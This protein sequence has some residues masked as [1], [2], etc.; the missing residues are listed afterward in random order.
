MRLGASAYGASIRRD[1]SERA[2]RDYAIGT[3]YTTMQRLEE[4]RL[5]VS[6]MSE[7]VAIRGGRAKRCF[8]VTAAGDAV[9]RRERRATAAKWQGIPGRLRLA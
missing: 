4:K 3:I 1:L 6:A 5:V 9:V 2:K 7:P 8:R